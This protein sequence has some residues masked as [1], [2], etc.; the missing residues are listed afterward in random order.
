[1]VRGSSKKSKR[2]LV[3]QVPQKTLQRALRLLEQPLEIPGDRSEHGCP[4]TMVR[5][6]DSST[7][8]RRSLHSRRNWLEH[9][10]ASVTR[11]DWNTFMRSLKLVTQNNSFCGVP[12]VLRNTIFGMLAHPLYR[13]PAV[14]KSILTAITPC[15]SNDDVALCIETIAQTINGH[16]ECLNES[17]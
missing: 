11:H 1:M 8:T 12:A 2:K 17:K 16:T 5:Y 9:F 7:T 15:S 13:E 4:F 6:L 3:L 10:S 14:I